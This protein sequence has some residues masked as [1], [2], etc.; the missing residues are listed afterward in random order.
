LWIAL[1]LFSIKALTSLLSI[2]ILCPSEQLDLISPYL[3]GVS[4]AQVLAPATASPDLPTDLP[5]G[6]ATGDM[7]DN[8]VSSNVV[9]GN[10]VNVVADTVTADLASADLASA[11][12]VTANP[13]G[14][15]YQY[16]WFNRTELLL[17]H[18][19]KSSHTDCLV[20][21]AIPASPASPSLSASSGLD[22]P[23]LQVL[24]DQLRQQAL[25]FPT[26]VLGLSDASPLT[27]HAAIVGLAESQVSQIGST[28]EQ[29]ISQFIQL[30][31]LALNPDLTDSSDI[32]LKRN[33]TAQQLRLAEKLKER[34]DYLGV[35]YKRNPR[36]FLRYMNPPQKTDLLR[37]L[38]QAYR[39]IILI[40]FANDAQLYDLIDQ[41]VNEVFFADVP[42]SQVVQI[43]MDLMDEFSKQLKLEGRSDEMLLDYR[44]TLIDTLAHLC[45]MYRRSIPRES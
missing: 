44:L 3:G 15:H 21:Q 33:L 4:N 32:L 13:V 34:L 9:S 7:P 1:S 43:H 2:C 22:L 24:F 39:N 27:Y 19:Q 23:A 16:E 5:I 26:V 6:S 41:F 14:T 37:Q 8:V 25:F 28:I 30:Q 20:L 42:I 11:D 35:Y 45:E 31:P 40:Y 12:P 10:L 36:N 17:Q 18:I 29:A 38:K